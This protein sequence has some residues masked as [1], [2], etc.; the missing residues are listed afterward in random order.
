MCNVHNSFGDYF[1][2]TTFGESHG[3]VIGVVVDG[4][5]SGLEITQ[6]DIQREM[7]RRRPGTTDIVTERIE[8]DT[9]EVLSGIKD[10]KTTGA[11]ITIIIKNQNYN[12]SSYKQVKITPRPSHADYPAL[13]RYGKWVDLDGGG[14]FSGRIT[15]S[16]V[17]AGAVAKKILSLKNIK[18]VAYA[19]SIGHIV[20]SKE[21]S[22]SDIKGNLGL[23]GMVDP[24]LATKA[25]KFILEVKS[26]KDSIGGTIKCIS[27]GLFAGIGDMVFG[28]IESK[29]SAAIFAIPGIRGIEFGLGFAATKL[30]GSSYNDTYSIKEDKIICNTNNSGGIIGGLTTGMPMVFVCAVKPTPTIGKTQNTVDLE[31]KKDVAVEFQGKHDP[32][33]VPRVIPVIESMAAIVLVDVLMGNRLIP[34][35]I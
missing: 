23:S 35:Q 10:C 25:E 17:M 26:K 6:D 15:A 12:S 19:N 4:C 24:E 31:K 11:P 29:L 21:Y 2:I 30:R 22:I 18:I 28:S 20:D 5:P 1:R 9:V 7:N 32:C 16:F 33:I 27:E 34:I 14:R 8:E 3:K 13:R